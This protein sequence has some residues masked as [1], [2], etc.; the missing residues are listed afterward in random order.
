[1]VIILLLF[2]NSITGMY[3]ADYCAVFV[4]YEYTLSLSSK[5][6]KGCDRQLRGIQTP[7][8]HQHA[9]R[10]SERAQQCKQYNYI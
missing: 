6:C 7:G 9:V 1:M 10:N 3:I 4:L 8:V 2:Q 5:R